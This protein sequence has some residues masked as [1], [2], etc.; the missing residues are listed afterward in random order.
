MKL[1]Q[2]YKELQA[3]YE[4]LKN[5]HNLDSNNIVGIVEENKEMKDQIDTLRCELKVREDLNDELTDEN[6]KLKM[7]C[8]QMQERILEEKSKVIEMMNQANE[9]FDSVV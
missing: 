3:K 6:K 5:E 1:D 8:K 2:S 9:V 4:K 7:D